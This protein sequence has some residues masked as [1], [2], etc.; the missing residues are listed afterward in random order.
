MWK[1][2]MK[3]PFPEHSR[4]LSNRW[5]LKPRL[6]LDLYL[7]NKQHITLSW[8]QK[9]NWKCSWHRWEFDNRFASLFSLCF[10]ISS[11]TFCEGGWW[12]CN[13]SWFFVFNFLKLRLTQNLS[14][15]ESIINKNS[16]L[17]TLAHVRLE[18]WLCLLLYRHSSLLCTEGMPKS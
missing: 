9:K 12:V 15:S 6:F 10:N 13:S 5:N 1:N 3:V 16:Y 14:Q 8:I 4:V 11:K 7:E 18:K 2:L 17:N